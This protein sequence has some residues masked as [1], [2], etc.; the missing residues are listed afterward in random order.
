MEYDFKTIINH[1]SAI[2][3]NRHQTSDVRWLAQATVD[4]LKLLRNENC[5]KCGKYHEAHDG[6]C[7]GCRW[8]E[9]N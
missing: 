6:G 3:E 9:V 8:K 5:E 1:H 2:A 7:R 4:E